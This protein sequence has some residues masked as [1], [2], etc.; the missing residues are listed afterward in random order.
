MLV[1]QNILNVLLDFD[2]LLKDV[3]EWLLKD[4]FDYYLQGIRVGFLLTGINNKSDSHGPISFLIKSH[5]R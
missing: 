2:W 3:F 5:Q 4:V 1:N